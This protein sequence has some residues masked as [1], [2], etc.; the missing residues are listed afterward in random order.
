MIRGRPPRLR[1]QARIAAFDGN[2]R[3]AQVGAADIEAGDVAHRHRIRRTCVRGGAIDSRRMSR[4]GC[5]LGC[6]SASPARNW[7]SRMLR[8]GLGHV[9]DRLLDRADRRPDLARNRRIVE[10]DHRKL[11]GDAQA[12]GQRG[13]DHA[14]GHLVVGGEDRGRRRSQRKQLAR[15]FLAG[16]EAV[17]AKGDEFAL[18]GMPCAFRALR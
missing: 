3:R 15:A 6:G 7:S 1:E 12:H 11:L 2:D 10:A 8:R 5:M 9:A 17:V 13:L 16:M 14:A 4:A 18:E